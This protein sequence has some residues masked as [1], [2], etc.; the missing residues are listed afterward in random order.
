ML[1]DLVTTKS[2]LLIEIETLMSVESEKTP[3][4]LVSESSI[5]IEEINQNIVN[6]NNAVD[7]LNGDLT[8]EK[9]DKYEELTGE[10]GIAGMMFENWMEIASNV[11]DRIIAYI[12][13]IYD[14]IVINLK[15]LYV[16]FLVLFNKQKEIAQDLLD[17][18]KNK[19]IDTNLFLA[20]TKKYLF[21]YINNDKFL[22]GELYN[23]LFN[24]ETL[25]FIIDNIKD[26]NK[27][28]LLN[29]PKKEVYNDYI[30]D[31]SGPLNDMVNHYKEILVKKYNE[32]FFIKNTVN[33]TI[34]SNMIYTTLKR[35]SNFPF[36][37]ISN[38]IDTEYLDIDEKG[39]LSI[40]SVTVQNG[41]E[42]SLISSEALIKVLEDLTKYNIKNIVENDFRTLDIIKKDSDG[43]LNQ[44]KRYNN[45][46]TYALNMYGN[47]L[48]VLLNTVLK[49]SIN[50]MELAKNILKI[51]N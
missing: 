2:P 50:R 42:K 31:D 34:N 15:K 32:I 5:L 23:H 35:E 30:S 43:Y 1:S 21:M 25:K 41:K 12:K 44:T 49:Y 18:F 37:I 9:L 38:G 29:I 48:T 47:N 28:V 10:S 45:V 4:I 40:N 51:F 20:N 16:K 14:F 8:E 11:I 27:I 36:A 3:D 7:D 13:K 24:S 33:K 17:K 26:I 39:K 19:E 46:D 22:D 6:I